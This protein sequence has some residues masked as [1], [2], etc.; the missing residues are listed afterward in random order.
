M[1]QFT[2]GLPA[3]VQDGDRIS[4]ST[5]AEN[6]ADQLTDFYERYLAATEEGKIRPRPSTASAFPRSTQS[7]FPNSWQGLRNLWCR[8]Q[9]S[10]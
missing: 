10:C 9:P 8:A 3:L 2:E 6:Y 7:A 1:M 5:L 4:F